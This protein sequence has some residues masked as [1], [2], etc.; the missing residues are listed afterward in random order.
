M[1]GEAVVSDGDLE[2]LAGLVL[3]DDLADLDSDRRGG[4]E[5]ARG[6]PGGDRGQQLLGGGQQVFPL[7]G[8]LGR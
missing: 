8:P 4:G 2:V 6:N 3:A 1:D 5:S 7:A